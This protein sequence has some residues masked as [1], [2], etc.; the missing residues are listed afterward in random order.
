MKIL[1]RVITVVSLTF[2][3][4]A[5]VVGTA[6]GGAHH[7]FGAHGSRCSTPCT[8]SNVGAEDDWSVDYRH[9]KLYVTKKPA[10]H[11]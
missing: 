9:G 4:V 6:I 11:R 1:L 10:A 7:F 8:V 3:V 2:V 5:V